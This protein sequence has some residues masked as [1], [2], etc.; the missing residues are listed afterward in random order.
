MRDG[1]RILGTVGCT[2]EIRARS[3]AA[4]I[5]PALVA[6]VALVAGG[7]VAHAD[8]PAH[9]AEGPMGVACPA[10]YERLWPTVQNGPR[11]KL[12]EQI[13]D[14]LTEL[15]N[16]LG[17]HL[18]VLSSDM[19]GVRFDGRRR[20]ARVRLGGAD[21]GERLLTLRFAGD[22]HFTAGVARIQARLDL[23]VAGHVMQLELPDVEMAPASYRGE[24]G[25]EV[26]LPLFRRSW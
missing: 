3:V 21:R 13:T 16:L 7:G 1:G 17:A 10:L 23:G 14:E 26:R 24:R 4:A 9:A 22:V 25:V 6:L 12:S 19:L 18:D 15:G 11:L 8:D 5:A 20:L 2:G